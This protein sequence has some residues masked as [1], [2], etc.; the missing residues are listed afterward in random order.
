[1]LKYISLIF[2][3]FSSCIS[4]AQVGN[5]QSTFSNTQREE[6]N[7][8]ILATSTT[9]I[10]G[11]K[12]DQIKKSFFELGKLDLAFLVKVNFSFRG[13]TKAGDSIIVILKHVAN[14]NDSV[15]DVPPHQQYPAIFYSC[16]PNL[17][18]CQLFLQESNEVLI[19]SR[20]EWNGRKV[21]ELCRSRFGYA[22]TSYFVKDYNEISYAVNGLFLKFIT[23]NDWYN[24]LKQFPNV[25]IPDGF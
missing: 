10:D 1:M 18:C 2:L 8:E 9:I 17:A 7:K 16:G 6:G 22:A 20:N 15:Y 19:F 14:G 25:N 13:E 23:L 5:R 4:N 11:V 21:F 3:T 24:Y 12:I